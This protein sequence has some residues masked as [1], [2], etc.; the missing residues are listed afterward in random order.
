[1]NPA[2]I[3]DHIRR[4]REDARVPDV[5]QDVDADSGQRAIRRDQLVVDTVDPTDEP[6]DSSQL[7][8]RHRRTGEH[9][10]PRARGDERTR[11]RCRQA[12]VGVEVDP[13]K[14]MG[15]CITE[16]DRV[17]LAGRFGLDD[18]HAGRSRDLSRAVVASVGDDDDV[19]FARLGARQE[20]AEIHPDDG[21]LVVRR[22]DDT[23]CRPRGTSR[24]RRTAHADL[25]AAQP[26]R[27]TVDAPTDTVSAGTATERSDPRSLSSMNP[28]IV[29]ARPRVHDCV[30]GVTAEREGAA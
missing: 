5:G 12:H 18:P 10:G 26:R 24:L 28:P 21:F 15:R 9:A 27:T 16:H 4:H 1:M 2:V 30:L 11:R 20:G 22:H 23:H 7:K 29:R 14:R 19:E 8:L 17:R 13:R 25:H 3:G 6:T